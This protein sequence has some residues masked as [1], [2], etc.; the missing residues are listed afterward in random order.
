MQSLDKKQAVL[1]N[2]TANTYHWGCYGTSMELWQSLAELG[3]YIEMVNVREIH[4]LDPTPHKVGDFDD[5]D[6]GATFLKA[7]L[8]IYHLL[9]SADV[10]LVNGEGTLHGNGKAA[11]NLLY[12][13]YLAKVNFQKRVHLV[14]GSF[15]PADDGAPSEVL[16]MLYGRVAQKLDLL[17]PRET[18]S[19]AVLDR[20]GVANVLGFDCLPRFIHR[21]GAL[22]SHV[23][24]P[25]I[26]VAG[27]VNMT[28][29]QA[30]KFGL[31]LAPFQSGGTRLKFLTGAKAFVNQEDARIYEEIQRH[32]PAL[33][34]FNALSMADWLSTLQNAAC[35][36]SAR[37]HHT[38]AAVSVGLPCVVFP[39][40][41]SKTN[42]SL[43]ML[44]LDTM[45][46]LDQDPEPIQHLLNEAFLQ[47]L[48]PA[49]AVKVQQVVELA[50]NNFLQLEN[51]PQT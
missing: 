16:D 15:F 51:I 10:V 24:Q 9:L 8:R 28:R 48:A 4:M 43:A 19:K 17:V 41:T 20:L 12:L 3:Y 35:L 6:F 22:N 44:G 13:M 14:N 50:A 5:P 42:A 30:R 47:R 40:N 49:D 26:V 1:L 37:Y 32:C 36:V 29:E 27:G 2:F 25:T 39:S 23:F 34:C 31:L 45:Q 11:V 18:D 38:L 46:S 7:N 21:H 33:E